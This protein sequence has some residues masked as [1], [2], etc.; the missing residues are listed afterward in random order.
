MVKKRLVNGDPCEK[1]AQAEEMLRRRGLWERIDHV[2]WAIEGEE[3][4]PGN[5]LGELHGVKVAPFFIVRED[6]GSEAVFTSALKLI[7]T[8]FPSA[9]R[10][11]RPSIPE[12]PELPAIAEQLADA[13][14]SE[15]LRWGLE[16][17][18]EQCAIAFSGAEDVVLIEMATR[19]DL[20]FRVFTLDTGRLHAE[21]HEFLDEVSRRYGVEIEAQMPDA[22]Q[23]SDFVRSKGTNSFYR[24]GHQECCA[25]RKV[26]PLARALSGFEAWVT[27]ARR[28]QSPP[29]RS[30]L[31]VILEDTLHKGAKGCLVKLNPLASWTADQVWD[32]I[33][34]HDVPYNALHDQGFRSIGCA[35]CTRVTDADQHP[36]EGRWWWESPEARECGLHAPAG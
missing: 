4:S 33:R 7:R 24:D 11:Q 30:E 31:P 6:D 25:L 16:R 36:R 21:T 23:L 1:C 10:Q 35:P 5:R 27:G 18:G 12:L 26:A 3:N 15:I 2:I 29:T 17:Y 19:L 20:R 9:P 8:H 28:D 14:P 34:E 22:T 13:H 32:Y